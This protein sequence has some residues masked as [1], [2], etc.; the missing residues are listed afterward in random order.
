MPAKSGLRSMWFAWWNPGGIENTNFM[1]VR[2]HE[3]HA[4]QLCTWFLF[5]GGHAF[6][7]TPLARAVA[8]ERRVNWLYIAGYRA[9]TT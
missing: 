2:R 4:I 7:L 1:S 3:A 5:E 6:H 8:T 9:Q